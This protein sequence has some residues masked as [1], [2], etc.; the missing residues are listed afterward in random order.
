MV[1]VGACPGCSGIV[2][3]HPISKEKSALT[4][5]CVRRKKQHVKSASMTMST[6]PASRRRDHKERVINEWIQSKCIIGLFEDK[7]IWSQFRRFTKKRYANDAS[8]FVNTVLCRDSLTES[9]GNIALMRKYF[10]DTSVDQLNISVVL[11]EKRK[12]AFL[13]AS[14]QPAFLLEVQKEME[15]L[16][17]GMV[18]DFREYVLE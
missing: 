5:Q 6:T 16:L 2:I 10:S 17:Y 14:K 18:F 11:Y 4:R 15:R 1:V 9:E 8:D 12:A 7:K 3:H 13:D